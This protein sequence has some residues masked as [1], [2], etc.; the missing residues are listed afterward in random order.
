MFAAQKS[1]VDAVA[2]F[3]SLTETCFDVDAE[4]ARLE[5]LASNSSMLIEVKPEPA[6]CVVRNGVAEI[7]DEVLSKG[8]SAC[9]M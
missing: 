4:V 5:R 7:E 6:G 2:Q 3:E 8:A 9:C 1:A